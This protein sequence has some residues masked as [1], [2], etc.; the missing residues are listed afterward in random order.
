[1][2]DVLQ[3]MRTSFADSLTE[4]VSSSEEEIEPFE[5]DSNDGRVQS[6][7]SDSPKRSRL[8]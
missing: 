4:D 2:L 8:E 6:P 3:S 5:S 1:M 7:R